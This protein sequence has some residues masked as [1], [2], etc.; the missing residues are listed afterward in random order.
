[1]I[2]KI[3]SR[4]TLVI[5]DLH[6]NVNWMKKVLEKESGNYDYLITLGD[7]FDSFLSPPEVASVK[8]TANFILELQNEKYG[9]CFMIAGNHI[10]PYVESYKYNIQYKNPHFL[11]NPCS[12]YTKSKSMEVNKILNW[13]NWRKFHVFCMCQGFLFS[14]A[15]FTH[16]FI[17]PYL[18]LEDNLD[19]L[20]NETEEA[21]ENITSKPSPFFACGQNRGGDALFGGPLW[22]DK[23]EFQCVPNVRQVNGHNSIDL[24]QVSFFGKDGISTYK[25]T[26]NRFNGWD[27]KEISINIDAKQNYYMMIKDGKVEIKSLTKNKNKI[28]STVDPLKDMFDEVERLNKSLK[29][30][31]HIKPYNENDK[32]ST[33]Q[34]L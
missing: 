34:N 5:P 27:H 25:Q 21:L 3:E 13:E 4:K 17:K 30:V 9:P 14:H 23:Y 22:C 19:K 24:P 16:D 29:S 6:Q 8:E 32:S 2:Y 33:P 18:P 28:G 7:E 15:G 10:L 1:M 20:W 12:G 11:F 26:Y 31:E